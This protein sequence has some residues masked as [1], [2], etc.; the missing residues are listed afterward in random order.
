MENIMALPKVSTPTYD[1]KIPSTG[2]NVSYRPY[3]TKEEKAL[4]LAQEVGNDRSVLLS[5]KSLIE[6]CFEDIK[7]ASKL[8]TFDFE[9]L[10]LNLR[11]VSVGEKVSPQFTCD[12]ELDEVDESGNLK[13]CERLLGFEVN[14]AELTPQAKEGHNTK[15][16]VSEKDNIGIQMKYPTLGLLLDQEKRLKN[17]SDTEVAFDTIINCIEFIYDEENTYN[18]KD[19]TREE[20]VEFIESLP[21]SSMEKIESEFFDSMPTIKLSKEI[22][23]PSCGH[24]H[25]ID[26]GGIQDFF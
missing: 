1:L 26:L 11:A 25:K 19:S 21:T 5:L 2:K 6:A 10:F 20:L 4:L 8:T 22:V 17:A 24:V 9:Y 3:V 12:Q 18:A 23:C 14:F 15:I 13:K 7:D 16:V